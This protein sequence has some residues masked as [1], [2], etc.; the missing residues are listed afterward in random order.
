MKDEES[1][2]KNKILIV[3]DGSSLLKTKDENGDQ[4]IVFGSQMQSVCTSLNKK[5]F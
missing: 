5:G 3:D 2:L 4:P 1:K